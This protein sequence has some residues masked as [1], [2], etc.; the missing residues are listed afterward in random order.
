MQ[1]LSSMGKTHELINNSFKWFHI[2]TVTI[3]IAQHLKAVSKRRW[4]Q[5]KSDEGVTCQYSSPFSQSVWW[6]RLWWKCHSIFSYW[7]SL[8]AKDHDIKEPAGYTNNA[9]VSKT[10]RWRMPSSHWRPRKMSWTEVHSSADETFHKSRAKI[11]VPSYWRSV[12]I[13]R[14]GS[15]HLVSKWHFSVH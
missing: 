14:S 5:N 9:Q 15:V 11:D 4:C 8:P 10:A 6:A 7:K 2:F 12:S 3:S 13:S 1:Y